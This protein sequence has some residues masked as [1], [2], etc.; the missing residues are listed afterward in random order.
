MKKKLDLKQVTLIILIILLLIILVFNYLNKVK[1]NSNSNFNKEQV[2]VENPE[3]LPEKIK[4]NQ[5]DNLGDLSSKKDSKKQT[6]NKN[7][8]LKKIK[9]E[10]QVKTQ[11]TNS[12]KDKSISEKN[13]KISEAKNPFKNKNSSKDLKNSYKFNQTLLLEKDLSTKNNFDLEGLVIEREENLKKQAQKDLKAVDLELEDKTDADIKTEKE[14]FKE[15]K[16]P[17]ELLGIIKNKNNSAALILYQGKK[18][19]KKESEMIDIFM[20]EKIF[21]KSL[22]IS[23][24]NQQKKLKLW[25]EQDEN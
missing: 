23:Y 21:N 24:Q 2:G 25:E 15:L 7:K 11:K 19:L 5:N 3:L 6:L 22:I 1:S 20:I 10:I 14:I 12:T 9:K 16:L 8:N 13:L 4:L 17:F 18:V